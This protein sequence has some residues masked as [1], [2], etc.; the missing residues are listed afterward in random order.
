MISFEILSKKKINSKFS[1][2]G[3]NRVSH[4]TPCQRDSTRNSN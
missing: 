2:I 1:A 3:I 4:R